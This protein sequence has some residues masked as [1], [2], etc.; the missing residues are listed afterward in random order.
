MQVW[1]KNDDIRRVIYHPTGVR[2]RAE[3]PA[4]WPD[5]SYTARRIADGD[6]TTTDPGAPPPE[7]ETAQAP[8]RKTGRHEPRRET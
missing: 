4:D 8:A 1:P 3:G 5:D 7:G 2:F 6:V